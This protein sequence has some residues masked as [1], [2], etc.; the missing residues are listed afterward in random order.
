M[1]IADSDSIAEFPLVPLINTV[2][3]CDPELE[4]VSFG[5][6]GFNAL[7]MIEPGAIS[8]LWQHTNCSRISVNL[9]FCNLTHISAGEFSNTS[10]YNLDLRNNILKSIDP[11]GFTESSVWNN[12][13]LTLHMRTAYDTNPIPKLT[14][15]GTNSTLSVSIEGLTYEGYENTNKF[16]CFPNKGSPNLCAVGLKRLE[17]VEDQDMALQRYPFCYDLLT[18][19]QCHNKKISSVHI[20]LSHVFNEAHANIFNP[21]K[22]YISTEIE[23]VSI[24]TP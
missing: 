23:N 5:L 1:T 22:Q 13:H 17:F 4:S 7:Q 2:Y 21:G 9:N 15:E 20:D 16:Q 6:I 14:M 18:N 11:M 3:K 24:T 19:L 10:F 8:K 12:L